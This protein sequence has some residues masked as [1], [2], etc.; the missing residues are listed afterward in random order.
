MY[1]L[2]V[3]VGKSEIAAG[4]VCPNEAQR[5]G[6]SNW[7]LQPVQKQEDVTKNKNLLTGL[8]DALSR[9]GVHK[10]Y[11]PNVL[12][13]NAEV[14]DNRKLT[15]HIRLGGGIVLH[16]NRNV[17][18]D[19]T[20]VGVGQA[21]VMS[22]AGCPV[23]IASA[24]E[25]VCVAHAGRASLIDI[26]MVNNDEPS[27]KHFSIVNAIVEAFEERGMTRKDITM[28][29]SFAIP[30]VLFN[31]P[32]NGTY[33]PSNK[34]IY[35][36]LKRHW[37]TSVTKKNGGM[38]LDLE[39]LFEEQARAVGVNFCIGNSLAEFPALAHTRDGKDP[40][41]RNLFILKRKQQN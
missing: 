22:S 7:S 14:I 37:P 36:F 17:P 23:I 29:M 20:F 28:S 3:K 18:A 26:R 11:A 38:S 35:K 34:S 1:R 4:L 8:S 33:G 41:R 12:M 30:S 2:E 24:G 16:R 21:V 13:A 19:G 10:A 5:Y 40:N 31:H 25:Q 39:E 15:E 32:F 9:M 27:R 6:V